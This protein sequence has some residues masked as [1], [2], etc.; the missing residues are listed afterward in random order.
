MTTRPIR[1][2]KVDA[3]VNLLTLPEQY[4]TNIP[5]DWAG[6]PLP[7]HWRFFL[8][9][10]DK[11]FHFFT[12]SGSPIALA[13][14]TEAGAFTE[15][16]W[17]YTVAEMFIFKKDGSGYQEFNIAPNG[18]W[19]HS[20]FA[21]YREASEGHPPEFLNLSP[22]SHRTETNWISGFSLPLQNIANP[23]EPDSILI[24]VCGI[25][26]HAEQSFLS[27]NSKPECDPDFH[28]QEL[29]SPVLVTDFKNLDS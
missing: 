9:F 29:G 6:D 1:L 20:P 24:N 27:F 11:L 19:W 5:T 22:L 17:K 28:L 14:D 13:P 25:A 12:K 15:E 16:L 10:D 8:S 18:A 21:S 3:P 23:F 7:F 4:W 26:G 2:F